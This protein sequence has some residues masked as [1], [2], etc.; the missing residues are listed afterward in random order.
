LQ[1]TDFWQ[2]DNISPNGPRYQYLSHM[3]KRLLLFS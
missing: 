3:A 2:T 1:K